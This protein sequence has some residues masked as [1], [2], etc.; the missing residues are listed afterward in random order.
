LG[1]SAQAVQA[2]PFRPGVL[3]LGFR[4]GVPAGRRR[5]IERTAGGEGARQLGPSVAQSKG[6]RSA[7]GQRPI[8]LELRVPAAQVLAAVHKL[9]RAHEVAYAEPDYLMQASAVPNDP[10]FSLQWGDSNTGQLIPTQESEEVLGAPAGGTPG[11]DDSALKAW[12]VSTG[13]PSI[14]IGETDTGVNYKHPDLAENIWS[15]PGGIGGC[16]KGTHGWNVLN[17]TCFPMD[18]DTF[19][20][21]HGTH[22]AGIMGAV[23]DNSVGVAGMNWHTNILPVKWL[24]SN[25]EGETVSLIAALQWLLN[26]KQEHGVNI[27]VVNDSATF[28]GTAP[29]PALSNE[30][31]ALGA[32]GIL[33][34]T[35][36]GN[37]GNNNDEESV[38]R[39][40]CG[41]DLPNEICV[42]AT[43][44][45]DELPTWANY[46]PH[47]VDL[48]APGVSIYSTLR[49]GSGYGYLSG[50]SMA[51][52]QVSGAAALVLSVAPSLTPQQLK[53]EIVG[54]ADP[55]PALAGKVISG[56]RLDVCQA[57]PG[58]RAE[59]PA[60]PPSTGATPTP[61]PV[62][63]PTPQPPLISGLAI[64]PRAFAAAR[65]AS[66]GR[67]G[68][69]PAA[70]AIG[71]SDS[72]PSLTLF[73]ILRAEP[74]VKSGAHRCVKPR[75]RAS[76]P[77]SR[78]C[79]RYA[80][81][82][83]F[84]RRDRAGRNSLHFSGL[85]NGR[86]LETGSYRLEVVPSFEHRTGRAQDATFRIV[87][88][89]ELRRL[90]KGH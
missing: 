7:A 35:A 36:A 50:G 80:F 56:G 54:H 12:N 83:A 53:A 43:N 75:S 25:A 73:T 87:T 1:V 13:S 61:Q 41:Y 59:P 39:Y 8:P 82:G 29:E 77:R 49:E 42:T 18:D 19:Y 32:A 78:R 10:S 55:L 65:P 5:A 71:Y 67:K 81:I 21:G 90:T 27:R 28:I 22:V 51:A 47:T 3:L 2:T 26:A 84:S 15:N 60:P 86:D 44:N 76:V 37:S 11:A 88:E 33:F 57:M 63:A 24:N 64:S 58:C 85:V 38:R 40:P 68:S 6:G 74:G 72:E 14:V 70:A 52:A 79:T 4:A 16:P 17:S 9:R 31:E 46:G 20:G 69:A 48:A 34:V 30:I 62:P 66:A 45:N 23:G 89:S